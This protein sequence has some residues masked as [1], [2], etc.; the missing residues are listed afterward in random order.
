MEDGTVSYREYFDAQLK[1]QQELHKA[2]MT[3]L[4]SQ[5]DAYVQSS[6]RA[7]KLA[8]TELERRQ[9]EMNG[10]RAEAVEDKRLLMPRNLADSRYEENQKHFAE[11]DIK[12]SNMSGRTAAYAAV[13]GVAIILVGIVVKF[14]PIK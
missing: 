3:A 12:L 13:L 10:F 5:F 8:A 1:A 14:I 6:E 4:R 11:I 2:E 9:T 7:L